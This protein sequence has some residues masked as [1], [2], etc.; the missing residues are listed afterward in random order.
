[1]TWLPNMYCEYPETGDRMSPHEGCGW[2]HEFDYSI[3]YD[4]EM[5]VEYVEEILS[6]QEQGEDYYG[7]N[8][9]MAAFDREC[10]PIYQQWLANEGRLALSVIEGLDSYVAT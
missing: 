6:A 2:S 9:A 4:R 10:L 1:M 3:A 8:E 7:S 5:V